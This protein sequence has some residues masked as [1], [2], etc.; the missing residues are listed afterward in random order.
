MV[1]RRQRLASRKPCTSECVLPLYRD[2]QKASIL[3]ELP[4]F[5][6]KGLLNSA[7]LDED[8]DSELLDALAPSATVAP[9]RALKLRATAR[10]AA[11]QRKRRN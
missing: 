7:P 2:P 1:G 6:G 11:P 4:E 9:V 5:D 3:Q 8:L 10:A